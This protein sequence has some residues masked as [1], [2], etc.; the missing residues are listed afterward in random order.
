MVCGFL[1]D[2]SDM[3]AAV[4][5]APVA[6]LTAAIIVKVDLDILAVCEGTRRGYRKTR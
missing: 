2:E 4:M 1:S 6:A 5:A 3:V